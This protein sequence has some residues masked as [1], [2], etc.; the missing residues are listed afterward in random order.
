MFAS[1]LIELCYESKTILLEDM[2]N[3]NI[4]NLVIWEVGN[5]LECSILI[6]KHHFTS[7]NDS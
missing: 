1:N 6:R 2:Y 7:Q 3:L 5:K 4:Y